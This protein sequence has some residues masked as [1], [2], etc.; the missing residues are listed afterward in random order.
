MTDK[1]KSMPDISLVTES[2]IH[3]AMLSSLEGYVLAVVDSIEFA[4][5]RELSSGEHRYVYD[6][7]KGGI[8]RQTDGAEVNH[9]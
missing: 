8:T 7:V 3:D 5:S 9:G 1:Q 6:T 4:L 2:A